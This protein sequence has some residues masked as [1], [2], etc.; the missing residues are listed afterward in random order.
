M[1]PAQLRAARGFLGMSRERLKSASGVSV[2]TIKN[3][4]N[5]RFR[6][7]AETLAKLQLTFTS[8]GVGFF[9]VLA[10][11]PLWGVVLQPLHA[12]EQDNRPLT[13][14]RRETQERMTLAER[15]AKTIA[16][17]IRQQGHCRPDDLQNHGFTD[18]E[19]GKVWPM[20]YALAHVELDGDDE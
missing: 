7:Q 17:T 8:H 20:A 11:Y 12:S 1:T 5:G 13:E 18:A 6:P 16:A 2:E 15:V 4:E 3:L 19:I 9:D 14:A 10:R